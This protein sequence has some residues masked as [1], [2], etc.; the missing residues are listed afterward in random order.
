M[1]KHISL[2]LRITLWF[3]LFLLLIT[4]T[5]FAVAI[6]IYN[7][8]SKD[9]LKKDLVE[10]VEQEAYLL[11]ENQE[12]LTA[13]LTGETDQEEFLKEDVRLMVYDEDGEHVAGLFIYD[14]LDEKNYSKSDKPKKIEINDILYYYYDASVHIAHGTD[15]YV[16]GIVREEDSL[17]GIV[18]DHVSILLMIPLL[19][20][21]AFFG[22]YFLTGKFLEPVKKIDQTTEEIRK[23][24]DLGKRIE[25]I[26]NG[27]ELSMLS[28]HINSMFD[29]LQTN[30]EAEKQF[31]SAASHELRTPVSVILAQCEY[32]L[33]NAENTEELQ[34]ALSSIQKQGYK[35]SHM[36]EAL[37]MFTRMEQGTEKYPMEMVNISS[38]AESA[39]E[40][41]TLIAD[42]NISV[43]SKIQKEVK[44]MANRELFTLLINN[45]IQNAI[46][47]GKENGHVFVELKESSKDVTLVVEDDGVGIAEDDLKHIWEIFYRADKS[48]NSKGLGLGLSLVKRIAEFHGGTAEV[49]S[50]TGEGSRFI[51]AF[52]KI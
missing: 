5:F 22:G 25:F 39:C 41:F 12:M 32:A 23:S 37:L 2:K 8:Y 46:R 24:G 33:E 21:A 20:I 42:K 6:S 44:I 4:T 17:S 43:I 7:S 13:I 40:D 35:M 3:T 9:K 45:L 48:R 18:E 15:Y 47:Y 52:K 31:T 19:I 26:D 14:E 38:I 27:D 29:S 51:C 49:E 28:T 1:K 10:A 30:F 34:D 16:R 11:E 36:I 50:R